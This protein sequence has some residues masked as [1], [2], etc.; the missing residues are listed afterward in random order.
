MANFKVK[1][2][3]ALNVTQG[4]DLQGL[5][6]LPQVGFV[7]LFAG[8]TAPSGWLLCNGGTFSSSEYPLLASFLGTTTLPNL[9]SRSLVGTTTSAEI[10]TVIGAN[11]HTHA[12]AYTANLD[13][14]ATPA[15]NNAGVASNW[16]A[17]G[18]G[19]N[20]DHSWN[21]NLSTPGNS[22][23]YSNVPVNVTA[24]NQ[25]NVWNSTHGHNFG[26]GIDYDD[27]YEYHSHGGNQGDTS[28]SGNSHAHTTSVTNASTGSG[29]SIPPSIYFYHIIKA[30]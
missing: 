28:T 15:H 1:D 26:G 9:I 24:G 5:S 20:H 17:A 8:E 21:Y 6:V 2:D 25:A 14:A 22:N 18:N 23:S 29:S 12:S 16:S 11:T 7:M 4:S 27:D 10:G 19:A 3:L 13:S 30:G